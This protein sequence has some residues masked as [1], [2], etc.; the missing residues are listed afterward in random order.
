MLEEMHYRYTALSLRIYTTIFGYDFGRIMLMVL[1]E[2]S[3]IIL[4]NLGQ[5]LLIQYKAFTTLATPQ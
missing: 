2:P 5:W 3:G 1:F 4:L